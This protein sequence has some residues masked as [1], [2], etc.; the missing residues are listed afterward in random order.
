MLG[1]LGTSKRVIFTVYKRK[2][3]QQK[4][5]DVVVKVDGITKTLTASNDDYCDDE[6][7]DVVQEFSFV[8]PT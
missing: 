1:S 2:F 7:S 4:V 6:R 8:L 3:N 5:E